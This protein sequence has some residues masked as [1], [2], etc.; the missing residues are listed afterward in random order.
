MPAA[1]TVNRALIRQIPFGIAQGL[2]GTALRSK[3][4]IETRID[5]PA[6]FT[7]KAGAEKRASTKMPTATVLIKN[8]QPPT[9]SGKSSAGCAGRLGGRCWSPGVRYSTATAQR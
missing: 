2:N 3:T 1:L 4:A 9:C 5:R 8:R 7:S 6:P